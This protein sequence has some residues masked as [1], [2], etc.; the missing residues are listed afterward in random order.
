MRYAAHFVRKVVLTSFVPMPILHPS[1]VLNCFIS[2][3]A[4]RNVD[5]HTNV[6]NPFPLVVLREHLAEILLLI[7]ARQ[8]YNDLPSFQSENLVSVRHG[9]GRCLT[10]KYSI[11]T[12][13]LR[14][15]HRQNAR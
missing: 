12:V 6:N 1:S 8:S 9:D 11:L 14:L 7:S 3:Y 15:L 4:F 13:D 5:T 10:F 2:F